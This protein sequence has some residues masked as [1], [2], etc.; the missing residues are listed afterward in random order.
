MAFRQNSAAFTGGFIN[1]VTKSVAATSSTAAC[2]VNWQ[3]DTLT[4][5]RKNTLIDQNDQ[6]FRESIQATFNLSGPI[7]KDRLFFYAFYQT[8]YNK[9]GDTQLTTNPNTTVR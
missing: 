3:P 2:Y 4:E 7:I 6:D 9:F 5:D 8:N 1:A